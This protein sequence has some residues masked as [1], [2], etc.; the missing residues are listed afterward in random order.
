MNGKNGIGLAIAM[1]EGGDIL[2]LGRNL[3]AAMRKITADLPIG[4]EPT[5]V[6]N[7]PVVVEHAISEFLESL[8]QAIAIIMA[9]SFI[10]LGV[11]PGTVVALSI[12][13][14]IAITFP[15][16]GLLHIDLQRI[17]LGALIIALTLLVDDAMTTIDAMTERLD[18]G[19]EKEEAATFAYRTL[20]APM[21]TGSFITAAGF[22]PIGFA[23]SAAGEYTFSIFVVVG[24][25]LMLSWL[26][27]VIFAPLLGVWILKKPARAGVEGAR[28]AHARVPGAAGRRHAG[29]L[30][31]HRPDGRGLRRRPSWRARW[32][33]DSS[34]RRPTG[35]S[36]WSTSRCR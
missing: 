2:T 1:R 33:R 10:S 14:T 28:A 22:V 24:L 4:I 7:Q 8:W 31:H 5:L 16:M 12:P 9:V 36:S 29:A 11:R 23:R 27:A 6:A 30:G 3:D 21:L 19:D 13:L 35:R 15:I 26:V 32:C 34:S 20:A 17:S 18:A 25:A